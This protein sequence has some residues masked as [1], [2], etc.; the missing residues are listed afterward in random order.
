MEEKSRIWRSMIP[1]LDEQTAATLAERY[2]F[3]D[4]QIE[5]I[6]RKRMVDTIL[7]GEEPSFEQLDEYCCSE[8]LGQSERSRRKIGF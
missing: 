2:D 1:T 3:S 6:A 7:R 5:N 4:G 8:M